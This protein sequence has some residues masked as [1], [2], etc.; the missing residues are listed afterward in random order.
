MTFTLHGPR[1]FRRPIFF[2]QIFWTATDRRGSRR[3]WHSTM[4]HAIVSQLE[5]N[6]SGRQLNDRIGVDLRRWQIAWLFGPTIG[7]T[8]FDRLTS[9]G[10][11]DCLLSRNRLCFAIGFEAQIQLPPDR[12]LLGI[13]LHLTRRLDLND[14]RLCLLTHKSSRRR[15][16]FERYRLVRRTQLPDQGSSPPSGRRRPSGVARRPRGRAYPL[17][18]GGLHPNQLIYLQKWATRSVDSAVWSC[19]RC[20]SAQETVDNGT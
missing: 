15:I 6:Y 11:D 13:G 3:C 16:A 8:A 14:K 1:F 9:A 7:K 4:A 18:L 2:C 12:C 20:R 10:L 19:D 5:P 17:A